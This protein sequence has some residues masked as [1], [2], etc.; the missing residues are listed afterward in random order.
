M[1]ARGLVIV[2]MC[3]C[4]AEPSKPMQDPA[5][6][7]KVCAQPPISLPVSS[8]SSPMQIGP[9][10][11]STSGVDLCVHLGAATTAPAHLQITSALES[12]PMSSVVARLEDATFEPILDGW[13]VTIGQ[14]SPETEMNLEWNPPFGTAVDVVVWIRGAS[15]SVSTTLSMSLMG[16]VPD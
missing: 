9:V 7:P 1:D 5:T 3:G 15:E 11:V 6:E 8:T 4:A 12:G 10:S 14:A 13:D 16:P 2:V